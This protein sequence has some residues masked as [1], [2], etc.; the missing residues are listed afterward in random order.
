M[1]LISTETDGAT[2]RL[3][4]GDL[5]MLSNA[6]NEVCNRLDVSEFSTRMGVQH[7]DALVLLQEIGQL[8][9]N[10]SA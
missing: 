2:V 5:L 9:R 3:T 8:Y 7:E 6:L 1:Q 4:S 10:V